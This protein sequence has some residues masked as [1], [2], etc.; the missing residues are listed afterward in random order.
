MSHQEQLIDQETFITKLALEILEGR[1]FDVTGKKCSYEMLF[2]N[3]VSQDSDQEEEG[4]SSAHPS[5][6]L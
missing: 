6:A 4:N 1:S 5:V 3:V 2:N